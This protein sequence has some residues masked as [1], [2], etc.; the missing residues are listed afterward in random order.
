M[1]RKGFVLDVFPI[2]SLLFVVA[3]LFVIAL[4]F[5][6]G[7]AGGLNQ[8]STDPNA[9]AIAVG[10]NTDL[11]WVLDFIFIMLLFSLPVGSMILAFLNNIPPFFFFASIGMIL[12]A[13]IIGAALSDG[14]T[15]SHDDDTFDTQANRMPMTDY[16]MTHFGVYALF[17]I[18][19][20]MS[21]TYV[22]MK[23]SYM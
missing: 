6:S 20:I 22:K 9:T 7:V 2:I 23:N 17:C 19:V 12:L 11:G 14:W 8:T 21:G 10:M 16:V 3:I 13:V 15:S 18:I 5:M 4:N 1:N